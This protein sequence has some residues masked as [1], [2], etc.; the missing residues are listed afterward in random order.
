[1]VY[2]RYY[3][4]GAPQCP[5]PDGNMQ[6][7]LNAASFDAVYVQF[8]ES[9][10]PLVARWLLTRTLDNNFCGLQ[11]FNNPA[12]SRETALRTPENTQLS[13]I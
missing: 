1:M 2:L 12:V 7:V 5:F 3:I 8:C 6:E 13:A 4:S 10:S 11:N 9:A